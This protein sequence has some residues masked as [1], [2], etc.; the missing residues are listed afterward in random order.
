MVAARCDGDLAGIHFI[1]TPA[2]Q[3]R[4]ERVAPRL[5]RPLAPDEA[6]TEGVFVFP[7]FRGYGVGSSMIRASLAKLA[8]QG[9]R[10]GLAVIDVDNEASLRM[11]H[12]AGFTARP[13]MRVDTFRLG[14]RTSTFVPTDA[15]AWRRYRAATGT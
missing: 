3:D 12:A 11:F 2:H 15:T 5:Y 14:R 9:Y 7:A 8:Q 10:R 6:L 13:T 4:L 1:H